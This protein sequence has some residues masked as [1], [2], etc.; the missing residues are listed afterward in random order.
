MAAEEHLTPESCISYRLR[1]VARAAAKTFDDALR[2]AGLRNTQ[3]T[4]LATLQ[5]LGEASVGDLSDRLGVDQTTLTRNLDVLARHGYVDSAAAAD[6]R[7]RMLR[8]T[9]QGDAVLKRALPLWRKT[10]HQLLQS[11]EDGR[12][13]EMLQGLEQIEGACERAP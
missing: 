8:M 12:W 10:Q 1:R 9:A 13:A 7:F 5:H 6:G 3:F 4:L 2:P 11:L